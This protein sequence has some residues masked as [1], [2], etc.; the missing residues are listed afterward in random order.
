MKAAR[1]ISGLFITAA[2]I[3]FLVLVFTMAPG[4]RVPEGVSAEFVDYDGRAVACA[5]RI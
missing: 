1:F 5:G 4:P 3:G 2:A